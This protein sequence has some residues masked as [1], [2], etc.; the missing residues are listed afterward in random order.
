M[1]LITKFLCI[2]IFINSC[3]AEEYEERTETYPEENYDSEENHESDEIY[4]S[5]EN[6]ESEENY[7]SKENHESEESHESE[8]NRE[9]GKNHKNKKNHGNRQYRHPH[10][11]YHLILCTIYIYWPCCKCRCEVS[12]W[13]KK[14]ETHISWH[15]RLWSF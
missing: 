8:E 5:K 3:A 7:G 9:S 4:G 1:M 15:S 10:R 2:I 6:H 11:M 13:V 12:K 14:F